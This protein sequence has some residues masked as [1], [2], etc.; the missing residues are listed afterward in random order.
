[1]I[2]I[3][4]FT[5]EKLLSSD[6]LGLRTL[7]N[8]PK[9]SHISQQVH[10]RQQ[11]VQITNGA[12]LCTKI[13]LNA[14]KLKALKPCLKTFWTALK[15]FEKEMSI[16]S[17]NPCHKFSI[18][19]IET[20]SLYIETFIPVLSPIWEKLAEDPYGPYCLKRSRHFLCHW[21]IN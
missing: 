3:F 1:M 14:L 9:G 4:H 5:F 17:F 7:R 11:V 16:Y 10:M 15:N 19:F 2:Q 13:K 18:L 12:F 20:S 8:V 21:T 6:F